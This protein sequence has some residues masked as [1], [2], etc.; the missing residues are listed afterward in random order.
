M[1]RPCFNLLCNKIEKAVGKKKFK[2]EKY[3]NDLKAKGHSTKE[4]SMLL[5][6]IETSGDYIPGEVK[7]LAMTLRI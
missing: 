1:H 4:S 6:A 2:S 3:I 7:V 5:A